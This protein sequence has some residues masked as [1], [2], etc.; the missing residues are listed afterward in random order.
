ML[1]G[2]VVR[3]VLSPYKLHQ[4]KKAIVGEGG[5]PLGTLYDPFRLIYDP[6]DG[7]KIPSLQLPEDLTPERLGDRRKLLQAM[8]DLRRHAD[9]LRSAGRSNLIR[10]SPARS[11]KTRLA[12]FSLTSKLS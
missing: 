10:P 3:L 7:T 4:G 5:G 8:E 2:Q 1:K 9:L 11:D 12:V 6:A